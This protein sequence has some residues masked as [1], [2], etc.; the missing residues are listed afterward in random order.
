MGPRIWWVGAVLDVILLLPALYMA[1]GAVD[2]AVRSEGSPAAVGVATLFTALPIFCILAPFAAWRA[3]NRA[4][5]A[6]QIVVLLAAP[7]VY[8]VFLVAFLFS[9]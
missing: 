3:S 2:I 1:L 7:W 4:R 6:I 8:G 9:T 5:P